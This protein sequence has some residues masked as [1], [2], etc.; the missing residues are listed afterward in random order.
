MR[1]ARPRLAPALA[2]AAFA[3]SSIAAA[4]S[5][6]PADVPVLPPAGRFLL[7]LEAGWY[8]PSAFVD[9]EG[10]SQD[11]SGS[12]DFVLGTLRLSYSP[13]RR[14]AAGIELPYRYSRLP[15]PEGSV[16]TASG[17]PGAGIYL[18]WAPV[19]SSKLDSALRL[20][21][22]HSRSVSDEALTLSD[23]ADRYSLDASLF[24]A[25]TPQGPRWRG[26]AHS[27]VRYAPSTRQTS[28][29][30]DWEIDLRWGCAIARAGGAEI[31]ALALGGYAISSAARQEGLALHD[32]KSRRALAGFV[33]EAD[34][35]RGTPSSRG[36][37]LIVERDL[38][39]R[40][41]LS[42]WRLTMTWTGPF[43]K[44][45]GR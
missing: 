10:V 3:V 12:P 4:Q 38:G 44:S 28:S 33:L 8:R 39:A 11:F 18:D 27:G 30:A 9:S 21:Y 22:F 2:C 5:P 36:I 25:E 13:V 43:G 14:L 20:E 29:L 41:S 17:I 23:G 42:G 40:N 34:R 32:L 1:G 26:G 7:R 37:A 15:V 16:L 24:T 6:R 35:D 19:R 31:A 45:A